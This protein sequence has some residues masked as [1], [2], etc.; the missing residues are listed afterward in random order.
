M[1]EFFY[2]NMLIFHK[3]IIPC[4]NKEKNMYYA[5]LIWTKFSTLILKFNKII[6]IFENLAYNIKKL[7]IWIK[8]LKLFNAN[9]IKNLAFSH[10]CKLNYVN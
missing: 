9:N 10:I 5:M 7:N 8:L 2:I 3:M 1:F 6:K 4:E